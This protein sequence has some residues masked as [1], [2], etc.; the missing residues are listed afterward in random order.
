M[1]KRTKIV[2]M[3]TCLLLALFASASFAAT[4]SPRVTISLLEYNPNPVQPGQTMDLLLQLDNLGTATQDAS[5]EVVEEYPFTLRDSQDIEE[6]KSL[7]RAGSVRELQFRIHIAEDAKDGIAPLRI[8][9]R[10]D[11]YKSGYVEKTVNINIETL[12]ARITI[13][14]VEQ[15]PTHISPGAEG[16]LILTLEN[17]DDRPLKN[18]DITLDL[19]QSYNMDTNMDNMV[20]MQAMV[21]ARLEETDRRIASGLSPLKGA[22][23]MMSGDGMRG[24][25]GSFGFKAFSPIGSSNQK[26]LKEILPGEQVDVEFDLMALPDALSNIYAIPVYFNYNDEDNNPFHIRVDVPL[27]IHSE[28][29]LYIEM[30]STNLRT[31]DFAAEVVFTVANRGFSQLRYITIEL[32]ED[33]TV[34]LLTAPKSIYIGDLAPGEAKEGTFNVLAEDKNIVFPIKAEYRDSYNQEYE[35]LREI[36]FTIINKNYYRD[37][38]Y[39]MMIVWFVLG[40]VILALTIFYVKQMSR[41]KN[42]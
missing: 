35:Q 20:S 11:N 38:P 9:Y 37:L 15:I 26:T 34:T 32:E 42:E 27:M 2:A 41:K 1:N 28:P 10:D 19:T 40:G 13:L 17:A 25:S 18:I 14:G 3:A 30:K 6:A 24:E 12:D 29:E 31:T 5:L 4:N 39:E 33:E 36:P 22:T 23:P 21:N 7:G 16:K 8:R